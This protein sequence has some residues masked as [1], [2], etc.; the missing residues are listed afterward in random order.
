MWWIENI[1]KSSNVDF[2]LLKKIDVNLLKEKYVR[3]LNEVT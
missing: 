1:K 3:L 2:K